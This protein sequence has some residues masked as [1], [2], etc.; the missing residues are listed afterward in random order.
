M[1]ALREVVFASA[2]LLPAPLY[3]QVVE[4]VMV[5]QRGCNWCERWDAEIAAAYPKTPEGKAAPLRRVDLHALPDAMT[6]ASPPRY[7]PT[8]VL[9]VDNVEAGRIEGYP[10]EDFFWLMLAALLDE[11]ADWKEGSL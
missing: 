8:F 10:G 2:L 3:A 11:H 9:M 4:L 1:R 5:E 6:F 7:T